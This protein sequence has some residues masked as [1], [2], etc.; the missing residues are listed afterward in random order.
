MLIKR[1]LAIRFAPKTLTAPRYRRISGV[2]QCVTFVTRESAE[3]ARGNLGQRHV[4]I[5]NCLKFQGFCRARVLLMR[6][7]SSM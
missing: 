6:M 1:S 2:R 7:M 5:G 4:C 3:G